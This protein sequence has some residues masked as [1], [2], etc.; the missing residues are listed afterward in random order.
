MQTF[1]MQFALTQNEKIVS[2]ALN[3]DN[4]NVREN[5]FLFP[6]ENLRKLIQIG[7]LLN[8]NPGKTISLQ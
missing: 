7:H 1:K 4:E 8:Q 2:G 3:G 6:L 5:S